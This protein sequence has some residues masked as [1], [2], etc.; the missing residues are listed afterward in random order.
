[1]R[2]DGCGDDI[3]VAVWC[4]GWQF[5]RADRLD[6]FGWQQIRHVDRL[7]FGIVGVNVFAA[8]RRASFGAPVG[9]GFLGSVGGGFLVEQRLPVRNRDRVVVRVDFVE[10]QEAVAIA[11]VVDERCLERRFDARYLGEVDVAPQKLTGGGFE[12]ELFYAAIA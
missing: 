6:G 1:M 7:I 2:V 8:A 4:I 5:A 3:V 12:V 11:A 10:G 9:L